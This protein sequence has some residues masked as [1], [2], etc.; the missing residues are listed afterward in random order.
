M[1]KQ[2]TVAPCKGCQS[3]RE[4]CHDSCERYKAWAAEVRK[5]NQNELKEQRRKRW[6]WER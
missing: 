6:T 4:A 3:R 2:G 5:A 1:N